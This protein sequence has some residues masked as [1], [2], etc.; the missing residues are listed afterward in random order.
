[1]PTY[2]DRIMSCLS[3]SEEKEIDDIMIELNIP[4]NK[5]GYVIDAIKKGIINGTIIPIINY[6]C[7][8]LYKGHYYKKA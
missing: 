7:K 3:S 8:N 4:E 1:M 2:Y 5:L 6:N